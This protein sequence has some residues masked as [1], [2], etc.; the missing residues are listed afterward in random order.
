MLR[1]L[2]SFKGRMA[3]LPYFLSCIALFLVT[4][5]GTAVTAKG[6]EANIVL[7][8]AIIP[9][10]L[11]A[12]WVG[13][14]ISVRRLHDFGQTGWVMLAYM[15]FAIL[16]ELPSNTTVS[17]VLNVLV[18]IAA[19]YICFRPGTEGPNAYGEQP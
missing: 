5:A 8:L 10:S 19:L 15:A 12:L 16:A 2:F 17:A 6:E 14:A 1:S 7:L 4:Q 9:V 3:R 11:A 18:L 13:I